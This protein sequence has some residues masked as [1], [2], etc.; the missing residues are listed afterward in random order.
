MKAPKPVPLSPK[1]NAR[2]QFKKI[3]DA[4]VERGVKVLMA[5]SQTRVAMPGTP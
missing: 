3:L 4:T 5:Q 1:E 2:F